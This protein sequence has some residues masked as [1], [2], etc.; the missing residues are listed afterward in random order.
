MKSAAAA[1]T[2]RVPWQETMPAV[3]YF[4]LESTG[5]DFAEDIDITCAATLLVE[6]N[7]DRRLLTWHSDFAPKM[8]G[9][10]LE[11]LGG[12]IADVC[13]RATL[14][15]FNGLGY[16][17]RVLATAI[18]RAH[19]A[20]ALPRDLAALAH[21]DRHVDVFYQWLCEK[22]YYAG[23]SSFLSANELLQKSMSGEDAITQWADGP[24]LAKQA[25]LEYVSGDVECLRQLYELVVDAKG[26]FR[27]AK[28]T[29]KKTHWKVPSWQST[30]ESTGV[31]NRKKPDVAWLEDPPEVHNVRRWIAEYGVR[32]ADPC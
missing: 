24:L 16:D 15:T 29:G 9:A 17:L 11:R 19:A 18:Q 27:V 23:L 13:R 12:Y 20:S 30:L 6:D 3:L 22:G 21:S 2:T 31:Y 28:R 14:V 26:C 4:D 32:E 8:S 7:G 1:G 5:V 25:V 10:D